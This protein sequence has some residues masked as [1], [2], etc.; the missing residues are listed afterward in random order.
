MSNHNNH[1]REPDL[2]TAQTADYIL[3]VQIGL[4]SFSYAVVGDNRLLVL[5]ENIALNELNQPSAEHNFLLAE[6]KQRIIGLPQNGFTLVPVNLFRPDRVADFA[7]FLDV[8]ENEK[9]FSQSLDTENQVIYKVAEDI[10]ASVTEKFDVKDTV[11]GPRG[12][13]KAA[14]ENNPSNNDLYAN[15]DKDKVELLNFKDGKLRFYNTFEF[16]TAD[17]LVYFTLF[18]TGE[19]KLHPQHT[20][21]I[22]SGDTGPDD[23]NASHLAKF[24]KKVQLNKLKPIDLPGQIASHTLLTLTALS[25]CGSS[26][27]L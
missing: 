9:V 27:A 2:S 11:F 8:K 6:Y 22:L 15:I 4:N 24:F 13:I 19:L 21:L 10:A 1:Y 20:T 17:E 5:K 25:L 23:E 18:V 26:E 3:L 14:A 12:W 7:R 16:K